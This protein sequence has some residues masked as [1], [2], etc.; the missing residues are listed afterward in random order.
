MSDEVRLVLTTAPDLEAARRIVRGLVEAG[1]CACGTILPGATSIYRWQGV[2]EETAE[3][4]VVLKCAQASVPR[5]MECVRALHPYVL[6]ELIVVQPV[7]VEE[8]YAQWILAQCG[9]ST[10]AG[11]GA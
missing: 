1:V 2:L 5:L 6:P 9:S 8:R 7:D 3:C 4:Q 11:S 10:S